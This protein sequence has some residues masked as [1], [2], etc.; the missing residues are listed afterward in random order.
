MNRL[1]LLLPLLTLAYLGYLFYETGRMPETPPLI[2]RPMPEFVLDEIVLDGY[3][4]G[5]DT[6]SHKDLP[7]RTVIINLFA[8]WCSTCILEHDELMT[9]SRGHNIPIYGIAYRDKRDT[10]KRMLNKIGNPYTRVGDDPDGREMVKWRVT[11]TPESWIIDKNGRIRYHHRGYIKQHD[12]KYIFLPL[13]AQI[14]A[15]G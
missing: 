8:S 14:E 11:A 4:G 15:E 1:I 5:Y 2:D 13:I 3:D 9:L 10:V 12:I 7:R 6:L